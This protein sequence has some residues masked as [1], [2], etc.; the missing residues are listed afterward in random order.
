[1]GGQALLPRQ[2]AAGCEQAQQS[3]TLGD[4]QLLGNLKEGVAR[5][6]GVLGAEAILCIKQGWVEAHLVIVT[7]PG[8]A[9]AGS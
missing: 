7:M 3:H 4:I 9:A 5:L 8:S 6:D 1:M 2:A